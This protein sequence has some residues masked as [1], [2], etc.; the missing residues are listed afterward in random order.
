MY[1]L[2]Q[3]VQYYVLLQF[4]R[5]SDEWISFMVRDKSPSKSSTTIKSSSV[6]VTDIQTPSVVLIADPA[7]DVSAR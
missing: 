4:S 3:I 7:N 2:E 1:L 6:G 5:M